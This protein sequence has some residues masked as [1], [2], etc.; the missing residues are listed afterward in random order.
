MFPVMFRA[1]HA[2]APWAIDQQTNFFGVPS[3][4]NLLTLEKLQNLVESVLFFFF[5]TSV[6]LHLGG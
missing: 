3:L 1:S 4:R 5:F 2:W 6:S